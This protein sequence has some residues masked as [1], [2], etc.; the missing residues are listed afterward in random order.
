MHCE[1]MAHTIMCLECK[2]FCCWCIF[3]LDN[4]A[5]PIGVYRNWEHLLITSFRKIIEKAENTAVL[6]LK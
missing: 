2:T 3:I 6:V 1:I 5:K 4:M